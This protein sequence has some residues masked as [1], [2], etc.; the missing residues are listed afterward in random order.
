MAS[1]KTRQVDRTPMDGLG[2]MTSQI[3]LSRPG[4]SCVVTNSIRYASIK[5]CAP[6]R[7]FEVSLGQLFYT[8]ENTKSVENIRKGSGA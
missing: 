2:S 1:W 7:P 8:C 4:A 6:L 3:T 5:R